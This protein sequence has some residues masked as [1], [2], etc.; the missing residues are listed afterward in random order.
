VNI[1]VVEDDLASNKLLNLLLTDAGAS[2][3]AVSSAEAA[4]EVLETSSPA[5]IVLDLILPRMAGLVLVEQVKADP[6]TRDIV[7]LAVSALNGP[8]VERVALASGCAAYLRKPV[9]TATFARLVAMHLG[10]E[11]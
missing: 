9:D 6:K 1:L 10:D 8:E 3:T 4:L 5:L 2:V 7:I 11:S